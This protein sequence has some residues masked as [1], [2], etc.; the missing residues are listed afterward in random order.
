MI[1]A[2][3]VKFG[4]S[5]DVECY[6]Q[7][8]RKDYLKQAIEPTE[9][10]ER[11]T[12]YL[13]DL[14]QATN[15]RAT[16]FFL[17][18]VARKY[19]ELVRRACGEG[20]ELGVHGDIH[21][22]IHQLTQGQFRNELNTAIKRIEDAAGREVVG[23]RAPAFSIMSENLWAL[24]IL[25]EAG[26][27]YD[28]S[29][30]PIAGKRYGIPNW[31]REATRLENGLWELPMSV[32]NVGSRT[33]P[34]LGGG[35]FRL[36]PYS[37]TR[38]AANAL[39]A[40]GRHGVTY[41]HPHEF[42]MTSA[43]LNSPEADSKTRLRLHIMNLLQSTGRGQSMRRKLERFIAQYPVCPIGDLIPG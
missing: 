37:Y 29:I 21:L 1:N 40:D 9:E 27:R 39:T 31:P 41:F 6:Y 34:C 32:F 17:G 28:L 24:D 20:H 38:H 42:E 8:V 13:L 12:N 18:N 3:G 16:F 5:F 35:Y 33:L 15:S 25:A 36:F 30:F 22:Y 2:L 14:M 43:Q 26:L 11:N 7:I 10:V 23:H 4:L 19:P